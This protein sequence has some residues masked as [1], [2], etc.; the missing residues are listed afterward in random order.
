[1]KAIQHIAISILLFVSFHGKSHSNRKQDED[2]P[3]EMSQND[4][5][6]RTNL[7]YNQNEK[8]TLPENLSDGNGDGYVDEGDF[9]RGFN[10]LVICVIRK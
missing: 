1:M 2:Q 5:P 10:G 4:Q 3:S 9:I 7:Q 6:V 8:A